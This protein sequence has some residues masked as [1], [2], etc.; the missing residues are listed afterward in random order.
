MKNTYPIFSLRFFKAYLIQ[1]RPYLLFISGIA[2]LSG[3]AIAEAYPV[4]QW[5][6][7]LTFIPLFLGYGF[8]QALTDTWQTDTDAIS[9]PYRPLS[10]GVIS[11]KSV[12]IVSVTGLVLSVLVLIYLNLWN[13]VLGALSVFGLVTYSYFKKNFWFI[14]PFY[15][16]WIVGLLPVMGYISIINSNLL[17]GKLPLVLLLSFVSY[18]N[19]VLIGYLKDISADRETGYKTFPV[20]FG[21]DKTAWI[22]D[23]IVLISSIIVFLLVE[24]AVGI[25]IALLATILAVLGQIYLHAVKVK[26][27]SNAALPIV[28]TVRCFIIWHIAVIVDNRPNW[29]APL[30]IF[31]V[32]FEVF[33]F[34]RPEKGQI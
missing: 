32:V 9:A 30:L 1:C 12:R 15:N 11:I 28:M 29:L 26:E 27:E 5:R 7:W 24:T 3:I 31:Y 19:F 4:S 6:L 25:I 23:V 8:G 10:K 16:A 13:V 21:W 34:F 22:G 14:G 2:G 20:V 33:L 18:T 17:N